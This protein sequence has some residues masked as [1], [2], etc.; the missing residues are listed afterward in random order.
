MMLGVV[1]FF[2]F[3]IYTKIESLN[4]PNMYFSFIIYPEYLYKSVNTG[5]LIYL[6]EMNGKE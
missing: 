1:I 4:T 6:I 3:I 2:D 5:L